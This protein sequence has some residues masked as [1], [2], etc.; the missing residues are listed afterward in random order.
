MTGNFALEEK[1]KTVVKTDRGF[2]G[3]FDDFTA[4]C[5]DVIPKWILMHKTAPFKNNVCAQ[6]KLQTK[7]KRRIL[8][9]C[10]ITHNLLFCV[11][12]SHNKAAV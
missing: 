9:Y 11:S 10:N 2:Q 12:I 7:I 4:F 8:V 3:F 1:C 5:I 6:Q